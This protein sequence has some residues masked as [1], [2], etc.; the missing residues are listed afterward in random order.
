SWCVLSRANRRMLSQ[1][2]RNRRQAAQRRT[3]FH[4]TRVARCAAPA[5]GVGTG[6]A[7]EGNACAHFGA[8]DQGAYFPARPARRREAR[9]R[10]ASDDIRAF[11][12]AIGKRNDAGARPDYR[13]RKRTTTSG[14]GAAG[15]GRT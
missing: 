8:R 1:R 5:R 15:T 7:R 3:T 9:S 4:E 6:S 10:E 2:D 13:Q 14:G 12:Q 11:A